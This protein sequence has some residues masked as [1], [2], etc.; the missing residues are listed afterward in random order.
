VKLPNTNESLPAEVVFN[1]VLKLLREI[2]TLNTRLDCAS[3]VELYR[4]REM[5]DP[6][7]G[8]ENVNFFATALVIQAEKL[9]KTLEREE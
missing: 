6:S 8:N 5:K 4:I 9:A 7:R 2:Q 3:E 1:S